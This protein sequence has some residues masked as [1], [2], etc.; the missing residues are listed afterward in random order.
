MTLAAA[1]AG[2]QV[3]H[4]DSAHNVVAWARR[5]AELS[6]LEAAP[7]RWIVDDA[8]EFVLREARRGRTYHVVVADPPAFGH[9]R[10][11]RTWRL[12]SG[13]SELAQACAAVLDRGAV[14]FAVSCHSSNLTAARLR[15]ALTDSTGRPFASGNLTIPSTLGR[16]LSCGT[17]ACWPPEA[18][19]PAN[20]RSRSRVVAPGCVP[21]EPASQ[22]DC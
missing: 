14:L 15:R 12:E 8:L 2:A 5:N 13:L 4:V 22:H 19:P 18:A 16:E 9:G 17:V 7:I 3:T 6:C 11:G 10:R 21:P 1:A 20:P